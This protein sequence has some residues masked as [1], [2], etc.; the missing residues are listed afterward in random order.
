MRERER[1]SVFLRFQRN[2][3]FIELYMY[4][5]RILQKKEANSDM[6]TATIDLKNLTLATN[7]SVGRW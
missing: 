5:T 1:E 4:S 2:C 3:M 6:S 7:A